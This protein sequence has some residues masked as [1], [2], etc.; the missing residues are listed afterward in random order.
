MAAGWG[1]H[2][3]TLART[4]ERL[5]GPCYIEVTNKAEDRQ[6]EDM[7]G[8]GARDGRLLDLVNNLE[9]LVQLWRTCRGQWR[10]RGVS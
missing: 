3:A 8:N 2:G 10:G 1:E 7:R 6:R 5:G 4:E 9:E